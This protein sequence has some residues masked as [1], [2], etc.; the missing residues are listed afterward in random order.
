MFK[1]WVQD[2]VVYWSGSEKTADFECTRGENK[3]HD[4]ITKAKKLISL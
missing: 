3:K 1:T 4:V 2:N